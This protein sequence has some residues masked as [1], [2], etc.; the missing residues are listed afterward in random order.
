MGFYTGRGKEDIMKIVKTAI[1]GK[2]RKL[3]MNGIVVQESD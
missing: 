1:D 2:E 3:K